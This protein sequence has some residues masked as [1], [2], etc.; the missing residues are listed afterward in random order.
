MNWGLM[1]GL[2]P[3][4]VSRGD[5]YVIWGS[6]PRTIKIPKS[7]VNGTVFKQ[8]CLEKLTPMLVW[9]GCFFSVQGGLPA[10]LAFFFSVFL[11]SRRQ[12]RPVLLKRAATSTGS[13]FR[14]PLGDFTIA[15]CGPWT[16]PETGSPAVQGQNLNEAQ[17]TVTFLYKHLINHIEVLAL[18]DVTPVL[19][20][21]PRGE[22]IVYGQFTSIC[23][24]LLALHRPTPNPLVEPLSTGGV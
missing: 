11:G 14:W 8:R 1:Q 13:Q 9:V 6:V 12:A 16:T 10:D 24:S 18:R 2:L 5:P 22:F 4:P 17:S 21:P 7:Q 23:V 3:V 19:A 20:L 15:F